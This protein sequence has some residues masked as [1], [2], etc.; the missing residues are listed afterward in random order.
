MKTISLITPEQCNTLFSPG[1]EW[2]TFRIKVIDENYVDI[3]FRKRY[4]ENDIQFNEDGYEYKSVFV[5]TGNISV[6]VVNLLNKA[7]IS[8]PYNNLK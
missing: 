3:K 2:D 7:G 4:G 1:A 6:H 5:N 8:T